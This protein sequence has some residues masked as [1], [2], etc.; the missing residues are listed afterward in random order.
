LYQA[1]TG[2]S[3]GT[4]AR[5]AG[6]FLF[7]G[8]L[9][10]LGSTAQ[11]V[12]EGATGNSLAGH[13]KSL[14][15]ALTTVEPELAEVPARPMLPWMKQT[16]VAGSAMEPPAPATLREA[17]KRTAALPD[18]ASST[19]GVAPVAGRSNEV[20]LPPRLLAKYYQLEAEG[21]S[22]ASSIRL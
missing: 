5:L 15:Q 21:K 6:G 19:A 17:L 7:G 1:A 13:A 3:I 11:V 10:L 18:V 9:G 12:L 22:R 4:A 8:P 14:A 20:E 16:D 2:D